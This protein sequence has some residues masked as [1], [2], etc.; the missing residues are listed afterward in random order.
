MKPLNQ[1][2]DAF[3]SLLRG[4]LWEQDVWLELYGKPDF[5]E[6]MRFVLLTGDFGHNRDM[7][8]FEKYPY[9]LRKLISFRDGL[10]NAL[11]RI[12]IFPRD[13]VAYFLRFLTHGTDAVMKGK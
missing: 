10:D 8:Y 6:L 13:A 2:T 11:R 1:S 4:G 9:L 12:P 5:G 3:F 7:S